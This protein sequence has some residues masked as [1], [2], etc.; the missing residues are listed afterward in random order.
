MQPERRP[1]RPRHAGSDPPERLHGFH[2]V[3]AALANPRRRLRRLWVTR[4]AAQRLAHLSLD[5]SLVEAALPRALDRLAG[6]G[7]VHQG[8][9][10]DFAPL[11]Q[12]RLDQVP[13]RGTVVLLDQVTDPHNVG[14]IMRSCAAFGATALVMTARHSPEGSGVLAKAASGALE[15]VPLVKVTN[16]SRAIAELKDCG[17]TVVGLDSEGASEIADFAGQAPL[18]LVLGAEG[19]GLRDLTRKSC[20]GLARIDL[21]GAVPSLNVSNAAAVALYAV[22]RTGA[23]A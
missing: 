2:T 23:G 15:H 12:P 22:S 13:R 11:E 17:F 5:P 10:A 20:D 1:P 9:V 7:A 4:N 19:R 14:A 21:A 3:E 16:L 18:A 6:A 8:V